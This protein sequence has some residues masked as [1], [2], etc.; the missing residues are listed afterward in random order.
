L[1][2]TKLSENYHQWSLRQTKAIV[3]TF[4]IL[5]ITGTG[6]AGSDC[7]YAKLGEFCDLLKKAMYITQQLM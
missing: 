4:D 6:L 7:K 1:G 2:D 5:N 3:A